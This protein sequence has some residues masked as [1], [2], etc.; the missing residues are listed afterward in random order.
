MSSPYPA[1][2]TS[3][4]IMRAACEFFTQLACRL[5]I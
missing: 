3:E 2:S 4:V 1:L 5:T